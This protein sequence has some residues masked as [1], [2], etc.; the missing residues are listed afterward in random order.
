MEKCTYCIQRINAARIEAK[1]AGRAIRDGDVQPACQQAC[2]TRAIRFGDTRD[3]DSAVAR[4]KRQPRNYVLLAELN[5]RPRTSYLA[6][7]RNPHPD[8]AQE[9]T[10]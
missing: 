1:L 3:P 9:G 8:L 5:N 7:L 6:K 10:A 4:L 2:P